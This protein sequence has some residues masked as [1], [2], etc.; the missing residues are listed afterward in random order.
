MPT[1]ER[2]ASRGLCAVM[3]VF[4]L[5]CT[6]FA[7]LP[8][9]L[10]PERRAMLLGGLGLAIA[11]VEQPQQAVA[12]GDVASAVQ[13]LR[14]CEVQA[15]GIIGGLSSAKNALAMTP[16]EA[17]AAGNRGPPQL[18]S[19]E[20]EDSGPCSVA[21]LQ[22]AAKSLAAAPSEGLNKQERER[23]EDGPKRLLEARSAIVTANA[24]KQGARLFGAVSKY[25]EAT[26][27]LLVG[28]SE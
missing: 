4:M 21:E 20:S 23:L 18:G 22:A 16:G 5:R 27:N 7:A 26:K 12:A 2:R 1:T 28:R 3:L 14:E 11:A 19:F 17:S 24:K 9:R 15:K 25:L 8:G 13:K 10:L 6:A